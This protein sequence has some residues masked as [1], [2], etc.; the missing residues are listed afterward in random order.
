MAKK[1]KRTLPFLTSLTSLAERIRHATSV[2]APFAL[3]TPSAALAFELEPRILF[4][5]AAVVTAFVPIEQA[6]SEPL[7][8]DTVEPTDFSAFST[9]N[10][11]DNSEELLQALNALDR[12]QQDTR[13]EVVIIDSLVQ[14][15]QSLVDLMPPQVDVHILNLKR[16]AIGQ[17]RGILK[18]Y[19]D[20]DAIHIISH[21]DKG[22]LQLGDQTLSLA[23]VDQYSDALQSWGDALNEEGDILLYGCYVGADSAGDDFIQAMVEA[24][25]ADIAASDDITGREGDTLLEKEAGII[26]T[27]SLALNG[28]NSQLAVT[29]IT[30]TAN[31]LDVATSS[32]ITLTFD[33]NTTLTEGT[34]L[35]V[36][37]SISG[38]LSGA[39]SNNGSTSVTYNPD[40]DFAPGE[41][42]TVTLTSDGGGPKNYQFTVATATNA[43]DNFVEAQTLGDHLTHA[44]VLADID[45]DGDL[46]LIEGNYNQPNRIW[47]N[48]GSGAFT[49]SGQ[50]LGDHRTDAIALGDVDGDG[51]LDFI[52]G[53]EYSSQT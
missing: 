6:E 4:D 25:S 24:T 47:I 38:D 51:D 5:A 7:L 50:E 36:R 15:K 3:P 35:F 18:E 26:E 52:T 27:V 19:Q 31:A 2:P 32:D 17:I 30:P 14:E 40:A 44:T 45:S 48:D 33:T 43:L 39:L 12:S 13:R 42:V 11:W 16:Q 28:Y 9:S 41:T 29:A 37:G 22:M 20:L 10:T 49:D 8:D 1:K 46:D 34:N 53:T 21:G 23:T